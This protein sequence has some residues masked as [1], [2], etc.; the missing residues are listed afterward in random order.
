MA[1]AKS[2]EGFTQA[3]VPRAAN[4]NAMLAKNLTEHELQTI[5]ADLRYFFPDDKT[6]EKL[7][8]FHE[9]DIF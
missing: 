6:Y 2:K 5:Y 9:L 1:S 3:N 7:S 8:I 4:I